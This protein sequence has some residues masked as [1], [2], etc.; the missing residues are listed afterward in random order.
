MVAQA[1]FLCQQLTQI[2]DHRGVPPVKSTDSLQELLGFQIG[3][4][5]FD[6]SSDRPSEPATRP[7]LIMR[8]RRNLREHSL[9]PPSVPIPSEPIAECRWLFGVEPRSERQRCRPQFT[10]SFLD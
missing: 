5:P 6:A 2:S 10:L 9:A 1:E 3:G 8:L 7:S 4:Q